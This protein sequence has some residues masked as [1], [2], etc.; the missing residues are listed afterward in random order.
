MRE[1]RKNRRIRLWKRCATRIASADVK[2][3]HRIAVVVR[4]LN[5]D[6]AFAIHHEAPNV[7]RPP[8]DRFKLLAAG[9]ETSEQSAIEFRFCPHLGIVESALCDQ[10]PIPRRARELMRQQVRVANSKAGE[11]HVRGVR[12]A[13]AVGVAQK[14]NV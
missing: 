5:K 11:N 12:A 4:L 2:W 13:V 9:G 1:T 10:D 3:H 14:K 8:A 6:F 7:A